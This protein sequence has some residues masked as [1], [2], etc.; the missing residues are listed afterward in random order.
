MNKPKLNKPKLNQPDVE[1]TTTNVDLETQFI[2]ASQY[3][4]KK[5]EKI[6]NEFVRISALTEQKIIEEFEKLGYKIMR[7]DEEFF[8]A[9]HLIHEETI[10]VYKKIKKYDG[11]NTKTWTNKSFSMKEHLLLHRLFELWGWFNE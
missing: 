3:P 5:F 6:G 2:I 11:S 1:Q 10:Y 7:N 4:R 9:N 8:I